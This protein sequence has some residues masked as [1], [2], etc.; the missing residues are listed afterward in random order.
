M[1]QTFKSKYRARQLRGSAV[2]QAQDRRKAHQT[3]TANSITGAAFR[4]FLPWKAQGYWTLAFKIAGQRRPDNF[5][6]G[7]SMSI[8]KRYV[9]SVYAYLRSSRFAWR[10][11][12]PPAKLSTSSHVAVGR[13]WLRVAGAMQ[14]DEPRA[15]VSHFAFR[16]P[17][18]IH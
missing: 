12:W 4:A 6:G 10:S 11:M 14:L 8:R 7:N 2:R 9:E 16:I 5:K 17:A 15:I 13:F 1:L 3:R 18:N